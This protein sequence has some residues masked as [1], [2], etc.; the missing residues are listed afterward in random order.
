MT[1]DRKRARTLA[2][3]SIQE[4]AAAKLQPY[5]ETVLTEAVEQ[6][7]FARAGD[8]WQAELTRAITLLTRLVHSGRWQAV[9]ARRIGEQI[10]ACGPERKKVAA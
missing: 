9:T 7:F 3:A 4:I 10:A 1:P 6:L 8:G 2:L 5:E